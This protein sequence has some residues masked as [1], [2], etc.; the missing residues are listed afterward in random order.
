V[1]RISIRT[2]IGA[3]VVI[4]AL[5]LAV[6]WTGRSNHR[7]LVSA[8]LVSYTSDDFTLG[9][10]NRGRNPVDCFTHGNFWVFEEP[11]SSRPTVD[12]TLAG[13]SSTQMVAVVSVPSTRESSGRRERRAT[14]DVMCFPFPDGIR[15]RIDQ[16]LRDLGFH[17][18]DRSFVVSVDVPVE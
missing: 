9:F 7:P 4:F 17:V 2:R 12:F 11:R 8:W 16:L 14:L 13:R 15:S 6:M 5:A 3:C 1:S 18:A 10:T